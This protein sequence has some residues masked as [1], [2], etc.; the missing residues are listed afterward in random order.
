[1]SEAAIADV[2]ASWQSDPEKAVSAE[3]IKI[4]QCDNNET[5]FLFYEANRIRQVHMGEEVH[6][7]GII[8]FS[9]YC[10]KS[11]AYCG[12]RG[13]IKEIGRYR[14]SSSEIIEVAEQAKEGGCQ[15]VV[16]QSGE[17]VWWT[18]EKICFL[19]DEIKKRT[20]MAITLSIGE[21]SAEDYKAFFEAGCDR[22]LMRFETSDLE[23]FKQMHPDDDFNERINCLHV[24]REAGIQLGSG[25]LIGLP[26]NSIE[27]IAKD[28]LYATSL[29]L[30]MIGCGPFI[31]N[32]KTPMGN[33]KLLVDKSI[34]SKTISILRIL[35]P[36]AHI[37]ATTAFDVLR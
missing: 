1:M 23:L 7:R 34:Y 4:L 19:L 33:E 25:F 17:D 35:N 28:I 14:M 6:L 31:P 16:L 32:G 13:P 8:E 10:R 24:I 36:D 11:C 2:L 20:G 27:R 29:K 9:N 15:T 26:G 21:R 5:R 3:L 37:P 30:D 12:I 22:Y 18:R